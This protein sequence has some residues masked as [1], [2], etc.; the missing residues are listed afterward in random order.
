MTE[1]FISL[2]YP[3]TGKKHVSNCLF[4]CLLL[5]IIV[6]FYDDTDHA[7]FLYPARFEN[8]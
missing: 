5:L 8:A 4:A 3:K 2:A 7:T 1:W 6:V